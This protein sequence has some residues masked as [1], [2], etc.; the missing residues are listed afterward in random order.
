MVTVPGAF[1]E[2]FSMSARGYKNNIKIFL[3]DLLKH[4]GYSSTLDFFPGGQ[5]YSNSISVSLLQRNFLHSQE[6]M[7]QS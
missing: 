7:I 3:R 1:E 6:Q 5:F 4:A 2:I